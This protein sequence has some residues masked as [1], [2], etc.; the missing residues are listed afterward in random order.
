MVAYLHA[1]TKEQPEK[2]NK[3][4]RRIAQDSAVE[5]EN[6]AVV[7]TNFL[8]NSK[9]SNSVEFEKVAK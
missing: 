2:K 1:G 8:F 5:R 6:G 3:I 4:M 9:Y 7:T